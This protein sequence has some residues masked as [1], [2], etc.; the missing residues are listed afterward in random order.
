MKISE[1]IEKINLFKNE[2]HLEI[3]HLSD[4]HLWF[5]NKILKALKIIINNNKPELVI[6]TGD[7]FDI[8]KGAHLFKDFL[9]EIALTNLVV[10]IYGNHDRLYGNRFSTL[11]LNIPNCHCV[12]DTIFKYTSKNKKHYNITSWAN[13]EQLLNSVDETNIILVHNPK[14]IKKEAL[15][16]INIILSGHLHGGQVI[17]WKTKNNSNF[18]GTLFYKHCTDRKT[19]NNTTLIVSKGLGDTLPIRI[20][21]PR[22]IVKIIIS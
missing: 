12:E 4:I 2:E 10:F 3:I 15:N 5:S 20:N 13:K 14:K 9:T 6:F 8:P 17:L 19:I 11:F 16:G 1:R 22:E 7:Y 18:P 21:C